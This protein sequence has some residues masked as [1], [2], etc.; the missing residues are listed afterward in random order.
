MVLDKKETTV[1]YK[2]PHCGTLV[3]S[4]VGAFSLSAD[5]IKLKCPCGQS[6]LTALYTKDRKIRL[7]VPC[8]ACPTPHSYTVTSQVFFGDE[9]F[10]IPCALSGIDICYCGKQN[11][12]TAAAEKTDK[13]L[14]DLLG[15]AA[16]EALAGARGEEYMTDPQIREI[17]TFV[18]QDLCE[19]G[20]V[21][22]NCEDGK[23]DV[24]IDIGDVTVT[25]TCQK[26]G[27]MSVLPADSLTSAED[28]LSAESLWL[29]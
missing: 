7:T 2:C 17:V 16:L 28:F 12:V 5:M 3:M 24:M 19:A 14:C 21:H 27:A 15:D 22:C 26:C 10:R 6:E 13:M 25:V 20:E 4:L 23:P 8:I 29:K 11:E 9:L 1:A 18:V